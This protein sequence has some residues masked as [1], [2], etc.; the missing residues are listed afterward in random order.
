VSNF[1]TDENLLTWEPDL[2]RD[3]APQSQKLT[4]GDDGVIKHSGSVVILSA[5]TIGLV[6]AGVTSGHVVYLSKETSNTVL[7]D[8]CLP[9]RKVLTSLSCTLEAKAPACPTASS[10]TYRISTFDA[11][12]E[13]AHFRL[14]Q[15]KG[16]DDED[17][18]TTNDEADLYNRRQLREASV[19]WVLG[20]VFNSQSVSEEDLYAAK[21][22]AY[23]TRYSDAMGS[24]VLQWDTND[25][26]TVDR[27]DQ[28]GSIDLVVGGA[29]DAYPTTEF[30]R[31][32]E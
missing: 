7:Y 1:S 28:A 24:M 4:Q 14:C 12:H 19:Y 9:V 3:V 29:G 16:I 6:D 22:D 10:I 18:M 15:A 13:N 5:P 21:A 20:A 27:T 8:V 32:D 30:D 25:D 26:N 23:N 2:F 17:N 11:Q 31:V